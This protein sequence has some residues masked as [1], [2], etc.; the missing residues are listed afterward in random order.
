M[1][2]GLFLAAGLAVFC[3]CDTEPASH[4]HSG[5]TATCTERAVCEVCGEPYGELDADNHAS[6]E[7]T[8]TVNAENP[9]QHDK[10]H[11]CC[12]A[13]AATE[14]HSG[15]T[16]TS[17][18]KAVCELCGTEYGELL[19][20]TLELDKTEATMTLGDTLELQVTYEGLEGTPVWESDNTAVATVEN[21][22]VTAI[23]EGTAKITVTLE[24]KS[25]S[26]TI[27]VDLGG[28][29]PSLVFDE[30]ISDSEQITMLQ[31]LDLSAKVLF[32]ENYYT[33]AAIS[34]EVLS[35]SDV[36]KVEN[37]VLTPLKAGSA[38]V[39]VTASWRDVEA[40][41][42]SKTISVDISNVVEFLLNGDALPETALQLYT[43]SALGE[44]TY[45]TTLPFAATA[46]VNGEDAAV[47]VT[48]GG[49]AY[50]AYDAEKQEISAVAYGEDAITLSVSVGGS[51][52]DEQISVEVIRPVV[53]YAETIEWF[54]ALDG[55]LLDADGTNLLTE[56]FP[57]GVESA[58][59]AGGQELTVSDGKLLGVQTERDRMT[60]TTFT[61]LT[62]TYGYIFNVEAYTK[63]ISEA[64]DFSALDLSAD[65]L[66]V[67]GYFVLKNDILDMRATRNTASNAGLNGTNGFIGVF[68]GL[69]HTID[70]YWVNNSAA[71]SHSYGFFYSI[72]PNAVIKNVSFTNLAVKGNDTRISMIL[73]WNICTV[74]DSP[75][76]IENVYMDVTI[77]QPRTKFLWVFGRD[78]TPYMFVNN[79]ILEIN[80]PEAVTTDT[81]GT[82]GIGLF[83]YD[84]NPN[85]ANP[86]YIQGNEITNTYVIAAPAESGRIFPLIQC[87]GSGSRTP[88]STYAA[89]DF[90]EIEYGAK[91]RFDEE[92]NPVVDAEGTSTF[93]R[94][95]N[96]Y[97]YDTFA[98]L[99]ES[100][101]TQV[102]NWSV[103]ADG[104]TWTD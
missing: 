90:T 24:G 35:G 94:F 104:V 61:L 47:T 42:L 39:K 2:A 8:Y 41:T 19:E 98:A 50:V 27:T 59:Q 31:S 9:E 38:Q 79:F 67:D 103:S 95:K 53:E 12:G 43:V 85:T 97:R 96:V 66:T 75:A 34:Y 15:G 87:G 11:A 18:H 83:G 68:D 6:D 51:S 37:N 102:G 40:E 32:N 23:K 48:V 58:E 45:E 73:S 89:N 3:A 71:G 91:I 49:S 93:Y 70:E 76:R 60:E 46:Q 63:V 69:G 14:A 26:C 74:G 28:E 17:T 82:S 5:G 86:T 62:E 78:R 92:G 99:A 13:L 54:S 81:T 64:A 57:E 100:G 80:T 55:E 77:E 36:V 65:K 30:E 101:V 16:A 88:M 84:L 1:L 21:G 22:T 25:A 10:K 7:F 29:V 52:V 44:N 72:G 20:P 4:E 56:L 33:D